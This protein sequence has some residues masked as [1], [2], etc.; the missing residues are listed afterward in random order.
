MTLS[1]SPPNQIIEAEKGITGISVQGYKSLYEKSSIEIRPLTILAGANSSGKSSIMQPL[2]LMKQTL[3]ST[4]DPGALLINGVYVKF[5]SA[6][7]L[8]SRIYESQQ[9]E[10]LKITLQTSNH[11]IANTYTKNSQKGFDIS[12]V[13]LIEDGCYLTYDYPFSEDKFIDLLINYYTFNKREDIANDLKNKN[14]NLV[15]NLDI[16][17]ERHK[18]FL[19]LQLESESYY[20][21]YPKVGSFNLVIFDSY[22]K[23]NFYI[24]ELINLIYLPGLRGFPER[25]YP[26]TAI[27]RTF[28]GTFENYIASI[29]SYWQETNNKRVQLLANYLEK[30]GLTS[31]IQ[32]TQLNDVQVEIQVGRNI[33]SSATDMINIADV[34][35][36]VSQVV[37]ILV[38]LLVAETGQ[39]VYI[40]QPELHLHPKAQIALAEI[41]ADAAKKGV[42]TVI[43]THSELL[44]LAIQSLVA[45]EKLES[46]LVK[47]HWFTKGEDGMTRINSADLDDSGAF[48]DWPEDFA[49]ISLHLENRYLTAAQK[50]LWQKSHDC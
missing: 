22:T 5:T 45:E 28:P 38:A 41:L 10:H 7:Q 47:L 43:E 20:I 26:T 23:T 3:E 34:G 17:I 36:G 50:K 49:E 29:I 4:Y 42:K 32:A 27:G 8:F 16:F 6:N 48:G 2:L 24:S 33:K 39:L 21:D 40:E 12:Q 18:C 35:I 46:N 37:P 15:K 19:N 13:D 30:L 9:S 1:E 25:T 11:S 44:L 31:K 14:S